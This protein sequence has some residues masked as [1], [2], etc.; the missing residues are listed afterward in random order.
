MA[1]LTKDERIKKLE[2]KLKKL[3]IEK[4]ESQKRKEEMWRQWQESGC[5]YEKIA[6]KF[7]LARRYVWNLID[8]MKKE[9]RRK[10]RNRDD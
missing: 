10:I 8:D 5:D 7:N 3:K 1:G 2:A 6:L 4:E 9:K